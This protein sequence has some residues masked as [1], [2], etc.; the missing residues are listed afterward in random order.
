MRPVG[1]GP[2]VRCWNC[3]RPIDPRGR[4]RTARYLYR[5]EVPTSMIVEDWFECDCGAFQ[6]VRRVNEVVVDKLG[7]VE[8][9]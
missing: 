2:D 8:Q 1:P 4:I 7:G 9:A 5:G 3:D 6:N